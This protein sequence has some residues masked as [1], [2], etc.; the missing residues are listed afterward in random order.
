VEAYHDR[1]AGR[2]DDIYRGPYWRAYERLSWD[3]VRRFLPQDPSARVVDL[4]CGTGA[5]GLRLLKSGFPV[6]FVDISQGMLDQAERKA[7]ELPGG[8]LERATFVQADIADLAPLADGTFALAVAQ[9]D[10][11][12]HA[13]ER[14]HD[15]LRACARVLAPGGVLVA[16][17]DNAWAAI[18]HFLRGGEVDAL[19]RFLRTGR[20]EW[21][22]RDRQERFGVHMFTPAELRR[23]LSLAG[24]EVLDL[25]GKTVLP[26]R[27]HEELLDDKHTRLAL[28]ELEQRLCREEALLGRAAHLQVAAR[29]PGS[30]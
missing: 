23:A 14:A 27:S 22:A 10:P 4:G 15:A 9:G 16:S 2:Y 11:I 19:G 3:G 29:K 17:V 8:A 12:S 1:V 7:G 24:L 26:L 30:G 18:E 21:L 20:T 5:Y 25:Y 28:L 13:G 6:T